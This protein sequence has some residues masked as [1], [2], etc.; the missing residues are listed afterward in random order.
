MAAQ[1]SGTR[2]SILELL[3]RSGEMTASEL[4]RRLGVSPI[5]ARQHLAVLEAEGL[6]EANLRRR[7]VGRPSSAYRLTEKGQETFP[8][9]YDA[10]L[11][12]VLQAVRDLHGEGGLQAIWEWRAEHADRLYG[13]Q[14]RQLPPRE[15]V[16]ALARLQEETGHMV[17]LEDLGE[18]VTLV[19]HTC[20]IARVSREFP[21]ICRNE[22][23]LMQRLLDL[24]VLREACIA[25]GARECR[26]RIKLSPS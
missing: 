17:D 26:Y 23:V 4:G 5:A 11:L 6:V 21:D 2:A 18:E 19:E 14:M 7:A 9:L 10:A 25:E 15:R 13:P 8:R 24:A 1:P 20:P 3:K 22:L 16:N 12:L